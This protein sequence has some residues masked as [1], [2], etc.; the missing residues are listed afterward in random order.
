VCSDNLRS[1][2]LTELST[3]VADQETVIFV[4]RDA[5]EEALAEDRVMPDQE[6]ALHDSVYLLPKMPTSFSAV[7]FP[8]QHKPDL[9][10][11]IREVIAEAW[12]ADPSS[13]GGDSDLIEIGES[14][15]DEEVR[16]VAEA[17]FTRLS[18]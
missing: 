15:R 9:L 13:I 14:E 10:G 4:Y 7:G 18:P 11:L 2:T 17:V 16:A 1:I 6:V 3:R 12:K 8:A 5:I